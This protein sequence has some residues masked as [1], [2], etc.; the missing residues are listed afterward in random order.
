M[1]SRG[2][3]DMTHDQI[4]QKALR[5]LQDR[6]APGKELGSPADTAAYLRLTLA[7]RQ[8]EF[9]A[10]L[11][12]DNRHRVLA[13]EELFSGTIDGCSVHVR[14]VV[15]RALALNSAAV[16][17]AHNHPS[18]VC[19]PSMADQ[20]ITRR[21]QDALALVDIRTL[22]HV[23]VSFAGHVSFAERGLM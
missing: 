20:N 10:V 7:E 15:K 12:L 6:H 3:S 14:E 22:D 13:L 11:F 19:E 1:R 5:I 17:L 16:I 8:R 18:G 9:F 4:I 23:V 2:G 21:I